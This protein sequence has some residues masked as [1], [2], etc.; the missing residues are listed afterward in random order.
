MGPL[1]GI[2]V[3]EVG[4]IGPGPWCAM[5]LSDMGAEV[6]RLDRAG[7]ALAHQPDSPLPIDFANRRGRQSVAVDLKNPSAVEAVLKLAEGADAIIEGFRPGVAERLGIGPDAVLAR[8]PK[9]VYGR[10]TGWGQDGPMAMVPG[11][12]INYLALT[13]LL[14]TIGPKERPLPPLNLV[15]DFGGGGMLLAFGVV[16]GILSSQRTGEGQVVDAAMIDGASLLGG[17]VHSLAQIGRWT[18]ERE[19]NRHDGGAPFYGTYETADGLFVAIAAN[20]PQ[21]YRVMIETL[22]FSPDELPAQDDESTWP[23][24][25]ARFAAVFKSKTRDE[26]D[27]V[28]AGLETCYSPVL[29]MAEARDNAHNVSR[30]VFVE[31]DGI[32]QPAPA[33][34][35][36]KTPGAIAGP[37]PYPGQH[38]RETLSRWGFGEEEIAGLVASGAVVDIND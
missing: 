38:S 4:S 13:G 31:H 27:E 12:D 33:P 28:F 2:K 34:R 23:D 11:H 36:D 25:R 17:M 30:D 14:H 18:E 35:F 32:K 19:A 26:W 15:G 16:A 5:M 22:G 29:T 9:I 10:M 6:I 3:V 1:D 21:F 24:V 20:E 37:A 8:N 7:E